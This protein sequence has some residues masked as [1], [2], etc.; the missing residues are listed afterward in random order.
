MTNLIPQ[1]R[2]KPYEERVREL[3]LPAITW[4]IEDSDINYM[5]YSKL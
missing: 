2:N 1:F 5:K 3:K 4:K